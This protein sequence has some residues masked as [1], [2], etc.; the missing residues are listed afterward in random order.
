MMYSTKITYIARALD[1]KCHE[2]TTPPETLVQI[3]NLK[4][5][6]LIMHSTKISQMVSLHWSKG[7]P[8]L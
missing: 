5:L 2:T 1:K 6:F 3:Q 4:E 8:E 7:L